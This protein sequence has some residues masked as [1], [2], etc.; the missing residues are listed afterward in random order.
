MVKVTTEEAV[1]TSDM[2]GGVHVNIVPTVGVNALG[3]MAIEIAKEIVNHEGY[4]SVT[5]REACNLASDMWEQFTER[6]WTYDIPAP[7]KVDEL[8][9]AA[10]VVRAWSEEDELAN[11][12]YYEA[13]PEKDDSNV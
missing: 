13:N 3:R 7:I 9:A 11:N 8:K 1:A 5:A 10:P 4:T 6:G 12:A 2:F